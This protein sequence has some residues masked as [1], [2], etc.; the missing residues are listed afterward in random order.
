M[1]AALGEDPG[2]REVAEEAFEGVGHVVHVVLALL[3]ADGTRVAPEG[4]QQV[5][6]LGV[7]PAFAVDA[8]GCQTYGGRGGG[9][10]EDPK[11]PPGSPFS[12]PLSFGGH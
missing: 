1:S 3:E 12:L 8:F 7:L 2:V 6:G 11:T 4:L 10:Y 5:G 9:G